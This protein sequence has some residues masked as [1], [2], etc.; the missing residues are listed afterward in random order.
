MWLDF[1]KVQIAKYILFTVL[2]KINQ[3]N[4]RLTHNLKY[5]ITWF[6]EE[7]RNL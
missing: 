3:S 2:S 7:I 6:P 1:D 4:K 5:F